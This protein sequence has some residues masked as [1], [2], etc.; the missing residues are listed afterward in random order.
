MT[1]AL[2]YN[3]K[4]SYFLSKCQLFYLVS[5]EQY[6]SKTPCIYTKTL[7]MEVN[8]SRDKT[9]FNATLGHAHLYSP[10]KQALYFCIC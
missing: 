9:I 10:Q 1:L 4:A 5:P 6:A 7:Q 8:P 2:S 3:L